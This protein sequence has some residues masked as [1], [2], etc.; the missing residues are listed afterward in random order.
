MSSR[1]GIRR[2][3]SPISLNESLIRTSN[4]TNDEKRSMEHAKEA[5][6]AYRQSDK[7]PLKNSVKNGVNPG[8]T[9]AAQDMLPRLPIPDLESSIKKYLDALEP[10]QS[11]REH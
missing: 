2:F 4:M 3:T 6:D 5:T 9:Y 1:A 11:P 8:I 10:L 7:E